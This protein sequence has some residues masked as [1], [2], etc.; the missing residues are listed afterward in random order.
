MARAIADRHYNR[1]RPGSTQFVPPGR[2]LVLRTASAFWVTSWPMAEYVQHAW[3][4]AWMCTAFRNEGADLASRLIRDAVAATRARWP[5]VPALGM[6]TFVDRDRVRPKRD[7]G[8]CFLAAGFRPCGMTGSGL[9]AFQLL[10]SEMPDADAAHP[11]QPS[12]FG[13]A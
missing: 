12:L 8:Y 5:E 1:Q 9:L 3:A 2:C 10:P 4:G 6:V 11:E 7:P 13:V